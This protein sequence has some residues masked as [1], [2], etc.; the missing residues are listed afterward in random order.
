MSDTTNVLNHSDSG[1]RDKNLIELASVDSTNNYAMALLHEGMT[2]D[3]MAY[4]AH[5]QSAG[6]GQ[7]G[8]SWSGAE[9]ENIYLSL[10]L[11]P[12]PLELFRQF[13]LSAAVALGGFDLLS[14]YAGSECAIKWPNDLYWRDRKAAGILIENVS[15]G[16]EWIHAVAGIGMNVNQTA[17]DQALP[18]PTSLRLITGKS[19][20]VTQLARECCHA[21]HQR[22]RQ[23]KSDPQQILF[24]YNQVLY[25]T[26]QLV[27]LRKDN[28]VFESRIRLV[29]EFG[30]LVTEDAMER[31]FSVGELQFIV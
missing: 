6:K 9:G 3:G 16:N 13:M 19:Y 21:I 31:H 15:Q 28:I 18:N 24:D 27:K 30:Q 29:T 23:L 5:A 2:N 25:K 7:R 26:G 22:V 1:F 14:H 4:F 17:F 8:K 10:I 20:P 11:T 12:K